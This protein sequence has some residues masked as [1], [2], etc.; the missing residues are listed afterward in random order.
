M[1]DIKQSNTHS[2]S[3]LVS[4]KNR[5]EKPPYE[6]IVQSRQNTGFVYELID[7]N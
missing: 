6:L 7:W 2:V 1:F 5:S 3:A 4:H